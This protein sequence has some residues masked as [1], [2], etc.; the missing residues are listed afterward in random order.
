MEPRKHTQPR[1]PFSTLGPK[2][3]T[4]QTY[5]GNTGAL[6]ITNTTAYGSL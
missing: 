1:K 3:N 6:I 4:V 5:V 2:P